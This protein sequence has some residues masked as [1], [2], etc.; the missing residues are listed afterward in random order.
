[1]HKS[2]LDGIY[3]LIS[4]KDPLPLVFDSPH[5]GTVYPDDFHYACD[6]TA[7]QK[8]EDKYVDD[9]F[10]AAPDYG[11]PLLSALFPRAYL[12][13]NRARDD[14]D[15][16]LYAGDWPYADECPANPTNRS[17]AG[18]GLV[19]RLVQPGKPVYNHLLSPKEIKSRIETYYT[20][21]HNALEKIIE[22]AHYNYGQVWHVNCHSMPSPSLT[23]G[24]LERINPFSAP[25]FVL[26]DRDGTSCDLSF[27]RAL[28]DFIKSMGYK[29]AIN[30]PYKGVELVE[31]YSS[32]ATGR[33][34]IQ[35]EI[36]RALYLNEETYEKSRN[37]NRL[38][39]D[40]TKLIEFCAAYVQ[41][42]LVTL[43]A[44]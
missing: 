38:K 33:H 10:S 12:D 3:E 2:S 44:D 32:P 41:S 29:V 14:I 42:N 26:G 35:I 30:D 34:S 20:P 39:E 43:A 8:A 15:P 5:S 25:D 31:R 7:L 23:N 1:M 24:S 18:I 22:Q 40:I 4:P 17:Y 6:L 19:R 13:V 36:S 28:R 9:L 11:A 16:E 21:Y 27:T 37:Y